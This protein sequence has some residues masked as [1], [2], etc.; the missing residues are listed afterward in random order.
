MAIF[1]K[2]NTFHEKGS[3][4]FLTSAFNVWLNENELTLALQ[5]DGNIGKHGSPPQQQHQNYN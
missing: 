4:T 3:V 5:E 2:Q 1:P